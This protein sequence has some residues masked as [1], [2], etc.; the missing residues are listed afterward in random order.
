MYML[1]CEGEDAGILVVRYIEVRSKMD[2][3]TR[4]EHNAN[5]VMVR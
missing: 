4:N 2:Y 3:D 5:L 1:E